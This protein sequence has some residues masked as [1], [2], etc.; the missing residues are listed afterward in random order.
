MKN[1]KREFFIFT[2]SDINAMEGHFEEMARSGWMLDKIN[3]YSVKYRKTQPQELKFAIDLFPKISLFDYPE[4]EDVMEYRNLCIDAGWR[5]LSS[6]N[7]FQVF[8]SN[9][10]DNL[11]PIQTDERL[12]RNIINKS[13]WTEIAIFLLCLPVFILSFKGLLSF[14][15][16][17][18]YSNVSMVFTII[19]PIFLIPLIIYMGSYLTWMLRAKI[20]LDRGQNLPRTS[21]LAMKFKTTLFIYPALLLIVFLIIAVTHDMFNGSYQGGKGLLPSL[22]GITIGTLY[23]KNKNKVKRS[24][25]E[26]R[27]NFILILM[28]TAIG[29]SL[30]AGILGSLSVS[31]TQLKEGY[32]GLKLSDFELSSPDFSSFRKEGS[33]VLPRTSY[34]Y[35]SFQGHEGDNISTN[36]TKAINRKI[37]KYVFDETLK[38]NLTRFEKIIA[39]AGILYKDF[40]EAY[41]IYFDNDYWARRNIVMLLKDKEIFYIESSIDL[42]DEKN[43]EIIT[44]KLINN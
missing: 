43:I 5:F 7:K 21:Y 20:A 41:F 23:K 39:P 37:A 44:K 14:K 25:S 38:E 35:E 26:N 29:V 13:L 31:N 4:N 1:T 27:S 19:A 42:E 22:L 15:Y 32:K 34:Y 2:P 17:N 36:Y 8:Y 9:K 11:L 10:E 6:T 3:E 16:S 18:L 33:I 12:K 28:V 24:R 40:D 30:L